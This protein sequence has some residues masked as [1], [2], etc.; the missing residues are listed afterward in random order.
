MQEFVSPAAKRSGAVIAGLSILVA[1]YFGPSSYRKAQMDKEVD[2]L[3][4]VDGGIKV[5]ETVK[6][7]A[8]QFNEWGEDRK[9]V[10]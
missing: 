1:A 2:R 5:Y 9:S 10:V 4:A 7:P 3:C 6:L 8:D